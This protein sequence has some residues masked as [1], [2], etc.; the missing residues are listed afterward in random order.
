MAGDRDSA[1][2]DGEAFAVLDIGKTNLKILVATPDGEPLEAVTRAHD[3]ALAN[4]YPAIDIDGIVG[5]LLDTLAGLA[6]RH[7]IGA[8]VTTAH[9]CGAVLADEGGPVLPM[10]DY[11]APS[12]PGIDAAY[13]AEAPP[14]SEVFCAT[15]PGA[16]QLGKQLLWQETLYPE[17][18]ARARH[19]LTTAQ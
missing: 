3:F 9:G 7:R 15:G 6:P 2:R 10:M 14:F 11:E 19:H 16:M 4:P 8:I 1:A 12:P 18:F 13:A 5:W 17:R